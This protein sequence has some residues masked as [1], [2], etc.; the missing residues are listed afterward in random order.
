MLDTILS[1][2]FASDTAVEP[3]PTAPDISDH[4]RLHSTSRRRAPRPAKAE[5]AESR[6]R[7]GCSDRR[8]RRASMTFFGQLG[9]PEGSPLSIPT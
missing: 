6:E 3:P 1:V 4:L 5:R 2:A 9:N 7:P 8:R